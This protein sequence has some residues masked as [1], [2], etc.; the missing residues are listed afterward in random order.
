LVDQNLSGNSTTE[1]KE[2]IMDAII[3]L[4]NLYKE[5]KLKEDIYSIRREELKNKLKSLM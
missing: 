5:G 4:D 3:V 2:S 1:D